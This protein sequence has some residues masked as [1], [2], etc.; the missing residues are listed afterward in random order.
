MTTGARPIAIVPFRPEHG[1]AFYALNRAWLDEFA[2]YE[3]P[4]EV[5]LSDPHGAIVAPGGAL[6]VPL[7]GDV[8]VGTAGIGPHGEDEM[9]LLKLTVAQSARGSGIA[10]RLVASC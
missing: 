4:D 6:F 8:V 3:A 7:D 10:R 2:L 1:D 9:E 5:H